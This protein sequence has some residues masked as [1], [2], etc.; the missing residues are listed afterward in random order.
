MSRSRHHFLP[1][2]IWEA[3]QRLVQP[4]HT[5]L[6]IFISFP[7]LLSSPFHFP[8]SP[9]PSPIFPNFRSVFSLY[10]LGNPPNRQGF[11]VQ[12]AKR[13]SRYGLGKT[14]YCRLCNC[15]KRFLSQKWPFLSLSTSIFFFR[16][17]IYA[18]TR[19]RQYSTYYYY[20]YQ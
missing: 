10:F 12:K 9:L 8:L 18:W 15:Q 2:L 1:L 11:D 6:S 17:Y 5:Q 4:L 16:T 13:Q 3:L 7:T 19:I 14:H 20:S